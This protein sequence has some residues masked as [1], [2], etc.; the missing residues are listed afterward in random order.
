MVPGVPCQGLGGEALV[1]QGDSLFCLLCI[2]EP[3]PSSLQQ[4]EIRTSGLPQ[5]VIS[6]ITE[7]TVLA[8]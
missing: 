4:E 7:F 3:L 6:S 5:K 1:N 8:S 2:L